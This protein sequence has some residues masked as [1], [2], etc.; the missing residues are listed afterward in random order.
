MDAV[1]LFP[2]SGIIPY[3]VPFTVLE[4]DFALRDDFFTAPFGH[5]SYVIL[6]GDLKVRHKIVGPC[7]GYE[8]FYDCS[9]DTAKSLEAT[10]SGYIDSI[11][12]EEFVSPGF[13]EPTNPETVPEPVPDTAQTQEP[14]TAACVY[15][16]WSG[17][18]ATCGEG[19][20]FR[21]RTTN[22]DCNNL[23]ETRTCSLSPCEPEPCIKEFGE[24]WEGKTVAE[25]FNGPRDVAL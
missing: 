9:A 15:S 16:P 12:K 5:P 18:R 13:E 11:L 8:S 7:C 1:N 21:W 3:Q 19:I 14:T 24:T 20:Q 23:I 17:C 6:D 10:L 25:G 22:G 4:Q 2:N